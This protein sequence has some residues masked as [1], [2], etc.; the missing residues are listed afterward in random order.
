[1]PHPIPYLDEH[2][3]A[4][5]ALA[6]ASVLF[7]DLDGTLFAPG[8]L[9]LGDPSGAPSAATAQ[10][11]VAVNQAGLA[12]VVTTGRNRPQCMELCRILGWRSF[13]AELG[14]VIVH[15]L[16]EPPAYFL[17]DWPDGA[18][19]PGETPY[20]AIVRSGALE[21]LQRAFPGRIEEHSPWHVDREATHVLRG[22]IDLASARAALDALELPVHIID[23][24]IVR[25]PQNT[26][27]G[28]AEIHA[29]HLVPKGV[30]KARAIEQVLAHRGMGRADALAIGDSA[31][32]VEMAD[33]VALGVMVRNALDDARVIEEAARRDNVVATRGERGLGWAEFALAWLAARD[34]R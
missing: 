23:N 6:R 11:V 14:T 12:A 33:A 17:G 26:L 21:V 18:L 9:L 15:E 3:D 19:L 22:S 8:G 25:A 4:P 16:Y 32:D 7:T 27:T 31:T 34:S 10:A 29:Y 13:I 5:G 1:V 28:V 24:G 2:V 20:E 30:N